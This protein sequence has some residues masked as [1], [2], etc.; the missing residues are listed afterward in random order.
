MSG[1][2]DPSRSES[3]A[4]ILGIGG[5]WTGIAVLTW[6]PGRFR[7]WEIP[8]AIS[9]MACG[10]WAYLGGVFHVAA[11]AEGRSVIHWWRHTTP[12]ARVLRERRGRGGLRVLLPSY[13][14]R[15][16]RALKWP[17][18]LVMSLLAALLGSCLFLGSRQQPGN[19]VLPVVGVVG[20]G[21]FD[22]IQS[23]QERARAAEAR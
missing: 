8:V 21:C 5:F 14:V 3:R 18:L 12:S 19:W 2:P 23:W 9:M 15:A 16:C 11:R 7:P 4:L 20:F 6:S 17:P 22:V 10:A 13:F 1:L